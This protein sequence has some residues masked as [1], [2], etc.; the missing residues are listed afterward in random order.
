M[1][2]F[3]KALRIYHSG[4]PTVSR[5]ESKV[6]RGVRIPVYV[7]A[8]ISRLRSVFHIINYDAAFEN[9]RGAIQNVA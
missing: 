1:F 6:E 2:V 9:R 3:Y 4:Q 5:G 8:S 7:R